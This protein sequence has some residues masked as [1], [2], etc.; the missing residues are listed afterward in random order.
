MAQAVSCPPLTVEARVRARVI[1]YRVC[2][3]Q[4][5]NETGFSLEF[6][7]FPMLIS[8]HR[9]HNITWGDEQ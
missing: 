7:D 4:Y 8:F 5:G 9:A 1:P 2:D 6:F 3:E